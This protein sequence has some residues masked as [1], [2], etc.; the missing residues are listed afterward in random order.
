MFLLT[1]L[2]KKNNIKYNLNCI[3]ADVFLENCDDTVNSNWNNELEV[4]KKIFFEEANMYFSENEI[5]MMSEISEF[6]S[7][8]FI[9]GFI[10][11]ETIESN[12]KN[13]DYFKNCNMKFYKKMNWD[14]NEILIRNDKLFTLYILVVNK[15]K[16]YDNCVYL[17]IENMYSRAKVF[18]SND[19]AT[20]YFK[21]EGKK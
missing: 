11:H 19:I 4:N 3:Y 12:A 14:A 15:L 7:K 2:L 6:S 20:M 1:Q 10:N 8:K 21:L 9:K 16:K 17:P 13:Y 18:S 5:K